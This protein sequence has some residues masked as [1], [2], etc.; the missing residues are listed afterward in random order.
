[1]NGPHDAGNSLGAELRR[2][3]RVALSRKAQ[4]V[5]FRIAKWVVAVAVVWANWRS[6]VLAWWIAG[7]LVAGV[8][9]HLLWR[10]K[11]RGWTRPWGG[12]SDLEAG[13]RPAFPPV[14]NRS[15]T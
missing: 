6:P 4:P 12:W 14:E 8:S 2:E 7:G 11:T 10:W 15:D 1:M 13:S 5:W 3:L 9:V